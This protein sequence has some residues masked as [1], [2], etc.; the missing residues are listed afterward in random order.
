M[1]KFFLLLSFLFL[2]LAFGQ[3]EITIKCK[4]SLEY[5]IDQI[6]MIFEIKSSDS[7]KLNAAEKNHEKSINIIKMLSKYGYSEE[8]LVNLDPRIR[9]FNRG[10]SNDDKNIIYNAFNSYSFLLTNLELFDTIKFDLLKN[11]AESIYFRKVATDITAY[12]SKAYKRAIEKAK[13]NAKLMAEEFGCKNVKLVKIVDG[14]ISYSRTVEQLEKIVNGEKQ[15]S[16]PRIAFQV[17]PDAPIKVLKETT[18]TSLTGQI[19]ID[20]LLVFEVK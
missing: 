19:S 3:K 1:K 18:I 14:G 16:P 15:L 4:E 2:S 17:N 6:S 10:R 8:D 13:T 7:D 12:K 9:Q 11:G 20:L 5:P